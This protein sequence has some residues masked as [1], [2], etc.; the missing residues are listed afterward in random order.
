MSPF[1]ALN[2]DNGGRFQLPLV[3][4]G[5]ELEELAEFRLAINQFLVNI[6]QNVIATSELNLYWIYH[7]CLH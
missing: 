5:F 3:Y 2:E 4:H 6:A 1:F 7:N